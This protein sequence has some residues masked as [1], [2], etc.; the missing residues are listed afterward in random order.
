MCQSPGF[1]QAQVVPMCQKCCY[2]CVSPSGEHLLV[3][4]PYLDLT[5]TDAA[6]IMNIIK[7]VILDDVTIAALSP[8]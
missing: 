1:R 8:G 6:L 7:K 5:C 2:Y 3:H 4:I